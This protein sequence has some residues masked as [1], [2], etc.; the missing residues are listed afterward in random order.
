MDNQD[1]KLELKLDD[2]APIADDPAPAPA[3]P[4]TDDDFR[5]ANEVLQQ[6]LEDAPL[7][8]PWRQVIKQSKQFTFRLGVKPQYLKLVVHHVGNMRHIID[9]QVKPPP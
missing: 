3:E 6:Q 9:A 5:R 7:L 4:Q 1:D 8:G 2:P